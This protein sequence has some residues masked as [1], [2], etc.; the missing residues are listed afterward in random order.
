MCQVPFL[1]LKDPGLLGKPLMLYLD[2]K[3]LGVLH[4]GKYVFPRGADRNRMC[5]GTKRTRS[6]VT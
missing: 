4:Y 3:E 5:L 6:P 2:Q 1:T